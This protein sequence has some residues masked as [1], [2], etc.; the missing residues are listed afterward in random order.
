[1][2]LGF[3]GFILLVLALDLYVFNGRKAQAVS[4]KKAAAWSVIWVILSLSFNGL[5]WLYLN[6]TAT[7]AIAD[8]RSLEFFTGYLLEKSLSVDN[9]FVFLMIFNFFAVPP[10]Y[11]RRV[12]IY[13]V[14]GAILLRTIV[15]LFGSW[16]LEEFHWILYLFGA[17]LLLTG[18]K[19]ILF[20]EKKADLNENMLLKWLRKCLPVTNEFVKDKFIVIKDAKRFVTPL[21]LVLILV[22]VADLVFAV[23]SVPAVFAIT[24]DP[25]IVWTSNIFA[26]LGLRALFFLLANLADRF[27]LLK[28]GLAII[29]AF[30][31]AKMLLMDIYP[32]S[33]GLALL[34]VTVVLAVSMI[35]SLLIKPKGER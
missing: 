3:L 31:G 32:I 29:L 11:Q 27:H 18:I 24:T 15:I 1:M 33:I 17:F 6:H 19:M 14:L 28:F 16:L 22:E 7:P 21:F 9:M 26:I 10:E 30:I 23:D 8:A 34:I 2:W 35:G 20:A 4:M 25:F 5:L 12:L 13:G